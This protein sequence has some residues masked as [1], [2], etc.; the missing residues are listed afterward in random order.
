MIKDARP[1]GRKEADVGKG[2]GSAEEDVDAD[3]SDVF[4]RRHQKGH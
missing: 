1:G 4:G 2:K 3:G